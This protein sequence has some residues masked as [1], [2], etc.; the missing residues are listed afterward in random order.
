[1]SRANRA[2]FQLTV[3]AGKVL[4]MLGKMGIAASGYLRP[5]NRYRHSAQWRCFCLRWA[6]SD[7]VWDCPRGEV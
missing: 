3:S 6:L 5:A 7:Q 4:T 2:G 1:M